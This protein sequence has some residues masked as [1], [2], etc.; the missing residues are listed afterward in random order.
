M[1]QQNCINED[2]KGS[3]NGKKT[4]ANFNYEGEKPAYC[5]KCK[6]EGMI[7]VGSSPR[8]VNIDP[9]TQQQC[10]FQPSFNFQNE[11]GNAKA[12]YCGTHRKPGMVDPRAK[13]CVNNSKALYNIEGV[14]KASHCRKCKDD[15]M[16]PVKGYFCHVCKINAGFCNPEKNKMGMFYTC[17]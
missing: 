5:A 13:I 6:K 14:K 8:C 3:K 4:R 11:Q 2:C 9:I 15:D 16:V 1:P 17:R 12:R 10:K 7:S